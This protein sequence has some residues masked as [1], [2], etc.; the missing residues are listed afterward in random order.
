MRAG[1]PDTPDEVELHEEHVVVDGF[2][3]EARAEERGDP[4]FVV[5][6][7]GLSVRG[8]L[9]LGSDVHST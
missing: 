9:D 1:S 3:T 2:D 4:E 8:T 5:F 7:G 6:G